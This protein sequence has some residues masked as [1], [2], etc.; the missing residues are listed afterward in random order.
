MKL[1]SL[2]I[3]VVSVVAAAILWMVATWF[4]DDARWLPVKT[5]GQVDTHLQ[6]SRPDTPVRT[7]TDV[8][9]CEQSETILDEVVAAA[10]Y[11]SSDDDCTLFDFGYPIQCMTSVSKE[12]ITALRIAY[13][14]DE[15]SCLYRVYYD[16]PSGEMERMPICR[17]NR[18]EVELTTTDPLQDATLQYLGIKKS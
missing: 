17:N 11:C 12:Q 2:Q 5:S 14:R 1:S 13:R 4:E 7:L 16:C 3:G 15:N 6:S 18:C 9:S 8:L 10:R